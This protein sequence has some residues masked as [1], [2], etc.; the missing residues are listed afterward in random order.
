MERNIPF[1]HRLLFWWPMSSFNVT[2]QAT[3][4]KI[5]QVQ[6]KTQWP[7]AIARALSDKHGTGA[8]RGLNTHL[9]YIYPGM[10]GASEL[11][12]QQKLLSGPMWQL[13][14]EALLVTWAW[15]TF[16]FLKSGNTGGQHCACRYVISGHD[17]VFGIWRFSLCCRPLSDSG[18]HE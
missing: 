15:G 18:A 10:E 16:S 14:Q 2:L 5:G 12:H 1:G 7:V 8:D 11:G 9:S 4:S 6:R 3:C 17:P 13:I